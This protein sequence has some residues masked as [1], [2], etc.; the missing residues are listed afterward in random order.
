MMCLGVTT[1]MQCAS[2]TPVRLLLRSATT[3][4]TRVTPSHSAM[5]SGRF[6]IIRQTVSPF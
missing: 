1:L 4:P 5:Y 3:P 2:V 6:G